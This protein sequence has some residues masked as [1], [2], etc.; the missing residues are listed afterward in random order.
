MGLITFTSK[1]DFSR[2]RRWLNRLLNQDYLNAME[3]YGQK[4]VAA[5]AAAT[6]VDSGKTASSW[7]YEISHTLTATTITFTN[8]NINKGSNIAIL[9][10]YGHGTRTGGYVVGRDYINPAIRPT[11]DEIAQEAWREVTKV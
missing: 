8:S 1:G 7:G 5:L 3:R 4:G 11:F 9:L 10:Q 2:T 6:P